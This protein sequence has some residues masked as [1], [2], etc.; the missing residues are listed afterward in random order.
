MVVSE[1][2]ERS[3]TRCNRSRAN[4]CP[5]FGSPSSILQ[6]FVYA[7]FRVYAPQY[8]GAAAHY[9]SSRGVGHAGTIEAIQVP[10]LPLK[11]ASPRYTGPGVYLSSLEGGGTLS[12]T[13]M[14]W[15]TQQQ[16]TETQQDPAPGT[17]SVVV[18]YSCRSVKA[19]SISSYCDHAPQSGPLHGSCQ[20]PCTSQ[21]AAV[22][23]GTG[24]HQHLAAVHISHATC[25]LLLA[26][27]Q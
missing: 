10:A 22:A 27:L 20:A 8:S 2:S 7:P 24:Q 15:K 5:T 16:L 23:A 4:R 21:T 6:E 1:H 13:Q 26:A 17:R 3:V 19:T 25:V 11:D 14:P 9:G 18:C 12:L